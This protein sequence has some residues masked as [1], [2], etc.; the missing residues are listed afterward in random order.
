MKDRE[1]DSQRKMHSQDICF[2]LLQWG[3]V[4]EKEGIIED[5]RSLGK[6]EGMGS[7]AQGK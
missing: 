3:E 4:E 7:R 6:W 5:I 1:G 2:F